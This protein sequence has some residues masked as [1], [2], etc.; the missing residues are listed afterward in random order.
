M[1]TLPLTAEADTERRGARLR[2]A[3]CIDSFDV[4]GTE[5]NAVRTIEH[6]DHDRYDISFIVLSDRGTLAGRVRAAGVPIH[7]FHLSALFSLQGLRAGRDLWRHLR[8]H[9]IDVF[10]AHDIY[11]NIFGVVVARLAGVP[12]VIASR[13]WWY[14]ANRR[15]YLTLNRL[16]YRLAHR[17]LANADSVGQLLVE[18]GVSPQRVVVVPNFVEGAAFE[19]PQPEQ[20]R[21]WREEFGI[22]A[23]AQVVG[24]VANLHAVKDHATLLRAWP[25]VLSARPDAWLVLVGEG[26]ERDRLEAQA[27][28]LGVHPRVI[29]AGRRPSRPSLHWLFDVSVLCS[30]GEGFPNSVV[31]AMASA[32]PVVATR[33]G[34]I[35]DVVIDGTTGFLVAPSAPEQLAQRIVQ[36]LGDPELRASMGQAGAQRAAGTFHATRVLASLASLYDGVRPVTPG[37]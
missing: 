37:R 8:R 21:A 1:G 11:S 23:G 29:F 16:T 2:V 25:A 5:L 17:V 6:L 31:E 34:G 24:I 18:E 20:V 13:R 22:P 33:V 3:H 15:I 36:L 9:R 28:A 35:P 19:A 10:H 4:G 32:R 27:R 26:G 14:A 30:T 7:V 12:L